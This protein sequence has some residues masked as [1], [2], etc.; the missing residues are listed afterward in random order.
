[1]LPRML[2]E[3]ILV[4]S[5]KGSIQLWLP[6]M[7]ATVC[8]TGSKSDYKIKSLKNTG[9]FNFFKLTWVTDYYSEKLM[10]TMI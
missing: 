6:V 7:T 2:P 1:M 9:D 3:E 8:R 5:K 10:A 4:W